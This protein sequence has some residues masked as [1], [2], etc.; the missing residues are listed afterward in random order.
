MSDDR[1]AGGAPRRTQAATRRSPWPGWIW[2][3]PIA[4]VGITA[5]LL[6]R[7]LASAGI[8]VTVTFSEAPGMQAKSTKVTYRGV[9]IGQVTDLA[10]DPAGKDVIVSLA[11]D[12]GEKSALNSGTRFY[13]EGAQPSFANPSSLRAI[14]A[15]PTIVMIPGRGTPTRQ[16]RGVEGPPPPLL[17]VAIPYLANFNGNV[18]DLKAGAKVTLRGFT[19]G[20]VDSVRLVTDPETGTVTAPV[21]LMLD[22]TKFAIEG[23]P[24]AAGDWT[25]RLNATLEK[26]VQNGYRAQLVQVPPLI[27]AQQVALDRV[28]NASSAE[29]RFGGRY[30]EIPTSEG[31]GIESLVQQA[32]ALPIAAIGANLQAITAHLAT[33]SASPQL[34]DTIDHL[35]RAV[36]ALDKTLHQ[37]GPQIAPTVMSAHQAIDALRATALQLDATAAALR[38]ISGSAPTSP[39]GNVEHTLDELA[40]AARAVRTLADYLDQHPEALLQGRSK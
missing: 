2:A 8:D 34:R 36:A 31:G 33:L 38:T 23:K 35:D 5:W 19:V 25:A 29:L 3:I 17:V 13:L 11:I 24:S 9:T 39:N 18:G 26:L 10:L 14:V 16:F 22:P 20:D 28:A 4:A 21:I 32:G 1:N 30:P 7:E 12:P 40:Q 27:G 6:V 15:G 37:V